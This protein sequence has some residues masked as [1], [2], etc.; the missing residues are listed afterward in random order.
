MFR[1]AFGVVA[2]NCLAGVGAKVEIMVQVV[3]A[4]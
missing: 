3:L 1:Y 2:A 4:K